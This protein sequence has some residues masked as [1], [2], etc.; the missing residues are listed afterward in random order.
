MNTKHV[1]LIMTEDEQKELKNEDLFDIDEYLSEESVLFDT[2]K[3]LFEYLLPEP[4]LFFEQS[5]PSA[6]K[7]VSSRTSAACKKSAKLN[8]SLPLCTRTTKRNMCVIATP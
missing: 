3:S 8:L 5:E 1:R 6:T 4:K 7:A 2:S